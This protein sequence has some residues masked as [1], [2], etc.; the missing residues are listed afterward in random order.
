MVEARDRLRLSS[1]PRDGGDRK[2]RAAPPNGASDDG[3]VTIPFFGGSDATSAARR[4]L[5]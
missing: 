5:P 3:D 1:I 2:A 4:Q